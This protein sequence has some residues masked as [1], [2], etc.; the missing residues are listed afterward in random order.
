VPIVAP[1]TGLFFA[2]PTPADPPFVEVGS[3]VTPGQVVAIIETMKIFNEIKSEIGGKVIEVMSR[4]GDLVEEG[5]PLMYV[6]PSRGED[7]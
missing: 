6:S 3:L 5:A 4:D 7:G 2:G 1:L